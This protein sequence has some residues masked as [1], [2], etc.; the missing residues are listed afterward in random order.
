MKILKTPKMEKNQT[1]KIEVAVSLIKNRTARARYKQKKQR[2]AFHTTRSL[3]SI[4]KEGSKGKK[5]G[6]RKNILHN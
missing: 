1:N 3:G 2:E 4:T 6:T 5:S